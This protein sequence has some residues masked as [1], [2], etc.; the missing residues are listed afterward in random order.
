[1]PSRWPALQWANQVG[2]KSALKQLIFVK[3]PI[4][5]TAAAVFSVES[6]AGY[7]FDIMNGTKKAGFAKILK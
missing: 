2:E 1:M 5:E 3:A 4:L 7:G 6:T